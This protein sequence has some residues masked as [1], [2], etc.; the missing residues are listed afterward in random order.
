MNATAGTINSRITG[1]NGMLI[2]GPGALTL[3]ASNSAT[4][5]AVTVTG[6][7]TVS[8]GANLILNGLSG[9]TKGYVFQ[10]SAAQNLNISNG[11]LNLQSYYAILYEKHRKHMHG[12]AQ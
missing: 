11:T 7:I 8:G 12:R 10:G 3:T 9:T 2:T 6:G 5:G 1:S 4:A